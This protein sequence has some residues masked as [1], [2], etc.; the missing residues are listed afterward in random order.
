MLNMWLRHVKGTE[1]SW[2]ICVVLMLK[3]V[4][5]EIGTKATSLLGG[6]S[7]PNLHSF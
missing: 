7:V 4:N 6:I 2:N 1:T 5:A 3:Q